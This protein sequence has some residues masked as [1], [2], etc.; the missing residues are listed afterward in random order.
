LVWSDEEVQELSREFVTVT[1][2]VYMLYPE[3]EWNLKRVQDTPQ[4]RFF[5]KFGEAM[6]EG[7]WNH[8]GTKQGIYMIGPDGEYLEGKHAA[9]S[10]PK[11]I[12]KRMRRALERWEALRKEK[13][14]ANR[15]VPRV[16]TTAPPRVE[17]KDLVLRIH[18]RD[19]PRD[20]G[21]QCGVRFD[22]EQHAR[23]GWN[24]FVRW[25]W[26]E[27]W[28]AFDDAGVLVPKGRSEQAVDAAF[29]R[30]LARVALIDNVRGQA[31][32]WPKECVDGAELTMQRAG[33][34][35]GL[36]RIVYRGAVDL[37]NGDL[38]LKAKLYGEGRYDDKK[39]QLVS[40]ELCALGTRAGA[41]RFNQRSSDLGPAPIGFAITRWVPPVQPAKKN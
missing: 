40:F 22:P 3:D 10:F 38:W 33:K 24:K 35:D 41:H 21:E 16:V 36:T 28:L 26:N 19:L 20:G 13:G 7:D 32:T 11:D 4:H 17:G 25:A 39:K 31:N 27:N 8:P 15:P 34:V 12:L 23:D 29:V 18:S 5:K 37:D 1:D 30:T 14:Y 6:P 2:E 9:S